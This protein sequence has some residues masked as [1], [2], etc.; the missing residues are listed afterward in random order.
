[1]GPTR[2][3]GRSPGGGNGNRFAWKITWTEEPGGLQ[4]MW[5]KTQLSTR[6]RAYANV[7]TSRVEE[8]CS[9]ITILR[10]LRMCL[11]SVAYQPVA[12]A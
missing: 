1:M 7:C 11:Q 12:A 4:S 10:F 6:I 5:L 2:G 9:S 3:S 8:T